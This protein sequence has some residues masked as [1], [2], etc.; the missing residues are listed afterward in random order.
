MP[1]TNKRAA[2]F[3][4]LEVIVAI[5]IFALLGMAVV[6][7]VSQAQSGSQQLSE[8]QRSARGVRLALDTMAIDLGTMLNRGYRDQL[9]SHQPAL[10]GYHQTY[11][12][13]GFIIRWVGSQ[14]GPSGRQ[15][16]QFEYRFEDGTLIK[17][18][19]EQPDH[20]NE[21]EW[22]ERELV[23]DL[24]GLSVD[25]HFSGGWTAQWTL[26]PNRPRD[27]ALPQ[28]IRITLQHPRQGQL[29]KTVRIPN[30]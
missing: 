5:A 29:I 8:Q 12:E 1:E 19:R 15:L 4:L 13:R 7:V 24:T 27:L 30:G 21:P 22:Q 20:A 28:A 9:G 17:A 14:R 23:K 25:Y 26:A 2:G 3:T 6:L 11:P 16:R 10:E 18:W